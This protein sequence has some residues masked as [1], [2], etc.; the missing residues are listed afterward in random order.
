M[1]KR[2]KNLSKSLVSNDDSDVFELEDDMSLVKTEFD[3]GETLSP[4]VSDTEDSMTELIEIEGKNSGT[5]DFGSRVAS[6]PNRIKKLVS[7]GSFGATELERNVSMKMFINWLVNEVSAH[8]FSYC[9]KS[10]ICKSVTNSIQAFSPGLISVETSTGAGVSDIFVKRLDRKLREL[11]PVK[12]S[13]SA[14]QKPASMGKTYL[15]MGPPLE[16][17]S[18]TKKNAVKLIQD[19]DITERLSHAP[20]TVR[21]IVHKKT[22]W[23][24]DNEKA[25]NVTRLGNFFVN[26]YFNIFNECIGF[27]LETDLNKLWPGADLPKSILAKIEYLFPGLNDTA[28]S[29]SALYQKM[30]KKLH[31]NITYW[32]MKLDI[33]RPKTL[34]K[35]KKKHPTSSDVEPKDTPM[36]KFN[37]E[38]QSDEDVD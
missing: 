11:L 37:E 26:D 9:S 15:Y 36:L 22:F 17:L 32:R 27:N 5:F 6:A 24:S 2:F 1:L 20:A 16:Q 13:R 4:L 30:L 21:N 35:Y 3:E 14:G 10:E 33:P 28:P 12:E 29:D 31:N 23:E 8:D 18:P 7:A 34:G 25:I 19:Y 38:T